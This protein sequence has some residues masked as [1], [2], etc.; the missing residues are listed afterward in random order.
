MG[1]GVEKVKGDQPSW[2]MTKCQ[3]IFDTTSKKA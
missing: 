1:N 2:K 3:N